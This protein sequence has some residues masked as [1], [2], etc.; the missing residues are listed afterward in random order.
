[1]DAPSI[2]I[3]ED[4]FFSN[5]TSEHFTQPPPS[6]AS[7]SGNPNKRAKPS[8]PR[9]R[10]PSASPDPPSCASPKASITAD[11]LALEM[12]A[13]GHE[14]KILLIIVMYLYVRY[15]WK[16]GVKRVQDNNSEMTGHEFTLE[17]FHR[18]PLQCLELLRMSRESFV[19]LCAHFRVN[20]ALK[21]SKHVSVEEKMAMFFMMIRHNQR[22]VIIKR[23]FQH[24]KQTIHKFFHEVLDKM[25]LFA[26]DI[27]VPTSFNPNPNILGHNRRLRRVF[28]GAVSALDGTLI[29][30]VVPANKQDLYRNKGKGDC[31]QNVL[32]I[33]D[34]NMMFTFFVA[35]WE[36]ITHDSRILSEALANPHA[37]FSLPP[38]D[39]YYLCDAVYPNIRGFMAPYRNVRYWFGDFRRRRALM[40]KENFNLAHAKLRNV[41]EHAFGVLKARFPILKRMTPFSLVTQRNI[42]LTCFALHNFIRR[43]GLHDEYFARYDE[44]NVS[45]R[46]NNTVIVNDED[47]IRT[48]GTAAD[49]EYMTQL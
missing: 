35:G 39:K 14:K 24:S 40:N 13:M 3:D 47:E 44:P 38:P 41:I 33:C 25:L 49:R 29:H 37:P 1:M 18:N 20:Y 45:V 42:T 23:K 19:R 16:R 21:D 10:A 12:F 8:T 4:D 22:Y 7:P 46:N 34:F 2:N 48:H 17:L 9:P 43:E 15:F 30:V 28:K 5:H 6:A 26:H 31:Y 27:I 11:D 36:G 32:A